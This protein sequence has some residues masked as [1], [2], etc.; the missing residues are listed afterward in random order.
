MQFL[1]VL[2]WVGMAIGGIVVLVVMALIAIWLL[3]D[4]NDYKDRI[5]QSVRTSTGRELAMPGEIRLSLFPW[6]ALQIGPASLGNPAGFGAEPFAVVQRAALRVRLLPLLHKE[7][8]VGRIEI[9][10]LDLRLRKNAAGKGNWED[11]SEDSTTTSAKDAGGAK[12]PLELA[13]VVIRNSRI[14]F[15]AMVASKVDVDVG[16]VAPGIATPVK[17]QLELLTEAAAQPLHLAGVFNLTTEPEQRYRLSKLDLSGTRALK[18]GASALQWKF[19]APALDIDF[20]AQT[21]AATSFEAQFAA[22]RL[23][24]HVSG[25]S[26]IDAPEL[27]GDFELQPVILRELLT[28]LGSAPPVTRDAKVLT[29]LAARGKF[30]YVADTASASELRIQLDDSTLEGRFA[31]NLETGALSFDLSLDR[32]DFDRYLPPP[33]GTKKSARDEPFELPTETLKPLQAQGSLAIRQAKISGVT[34]TGLS[35]AVDA[36]QGVMRLAP[37]KAQL[38]GGQYSG[39]LTVDSRAAVPVVKMEQTMTG[40]DV[41]QLLND[42]AETKRLSGR[43]NVN[44]SLTAQGSNGAALIKSLRGKMTASLANGAVEGIDLWY[45]ISQAQSLIQ[46]QELPAGSNSGRTAFDSFKVSADIAGG[47]ATTDDLNIVS[48]QLRVTGKGSANLATQAIDYQVSATVTKSASGGTLAKIPVRITGS[49]DDPKIRPD[50]EG[51]AKERVKQEL[52]KRKDEIK[53]KIGEKL[54]G[55]FGN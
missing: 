52:D 5:A 3:F 42:L 32:I 37:F 54:K 2:K 17:L 31:T 28:Q 38:C 26:I 19:A 8:Q 24:G 9:D 6:L 13:G 29:Q 51:M 22:A 30:D 44:T 46:K 43:G 11:F 16:R 4:P 12:Q 15:D 1:R 10:G 20:A 7:L 18:T 40:I 36:R 14:S 33:T 45:A 39:D 47:V 21:L 25:S 49:F 23:A 35:V 50:V 48:Q 41:A 55:L 27:H 53:E 34:F